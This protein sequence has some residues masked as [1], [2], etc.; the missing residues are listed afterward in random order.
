L[1]FKCIEK[2]LDRTTPSN[3]IKEIE[4]LVND[5]G[6]NINPYLTDKE[7]NH[8]Q[9]WIIRN[10][11]CGYSSTN[12]IG[13]ILNIFKG[14][15]DT[16]IIRNGYDIWHW[17]SEIKSPIYRKEVEDLLGKQREIDYKKITDEYQ[18]K[19]L[20]QE[21]IIQKQKDTIKGLEAHIMAQK[22]LIGS[23]NAIII[24]RS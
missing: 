13:T 2:T 11:V 10:L 24:S 16:S 21:N 19:I 18:K 17:V 23:L 4:F 1:I 22:E 9:D 12:D 5:I 20:E 6:V 7:D 14:R 8:K 15:I 3:K